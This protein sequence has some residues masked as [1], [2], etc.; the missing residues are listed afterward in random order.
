MEERERE[1]ERA[2]ERERE[3]ERERQNAGLLEKDAST[4]GPSPRHPSRSQAT[5]AELMMILESQF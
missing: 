3:R 4:L 1:R 2:R 5:Y